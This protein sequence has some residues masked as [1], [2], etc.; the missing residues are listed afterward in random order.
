MFVFLK[1][2]EAIKYKKT[3]TKGTIELWSPL[4]FFISKKIFKTSIEIPE[5]VNKMKII[6]YI[7]YQLM[8]YRFVGQG[9]L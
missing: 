2:Y 9:Y 1:Q 5:K 8:V 6:K 4:I 3:G 7:Y